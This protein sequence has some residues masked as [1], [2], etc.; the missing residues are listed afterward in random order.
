MRRSGPLNLP[1]A[2][3]GKPR[4]ITVRCDPFAVAFDRERRI[5]S[6]LNQIPFALGLM[7]QSQ[8]DLPMR[9]PGLNDLGIRIAKQNI[10][11]CGGLGPGTLSFVNFR[12]C[13]NAHYARK[14]L[15]RNTK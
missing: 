11:E 13:G 2:K 9:W 3:P 7:A 10:C 15:R 14:H 8:E 4:E 1:P 5:P 12:V 6:I